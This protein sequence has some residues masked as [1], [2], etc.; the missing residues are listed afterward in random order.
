M[1]RSRINGIMAQADEMIR[2]WIQ[3]PPFAYWTLKSSTKIKPSLSILSIHNV[4]GTSLTSAREILT[5]WDYF[6]LPFAMVD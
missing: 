5:P 2:L 6:C 3:L 1:K 4:A